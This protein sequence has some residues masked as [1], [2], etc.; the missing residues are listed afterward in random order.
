M[1]EIVE[2]AKIELNEGEI[3]TISGAPENM[4]DLDFVH[5][6]S[7]SHS[8]DELLIA[9]KYDSDI[10]MSDE[11]IALRDFCAENGL[12]FKIE[13]NRQGDLYHDKYEAAN[14]IEVFCD[15]TDNEYE[16]SKIYIHLQ[17]TDTVAIFDFNVTDIG[18][19]DIPFSESERIN[20]LMKACAEDGEA[21]ILIGN[22]ERGEIKIK[23]RFNSLKEEYGVHIEFVDEIKCKCYPGGIQYKHTEKDSRTIDCKDMQELKTV[24]GNAFMC[25]QID[26]KSV[27]AVSEEELKSPDLNKGNDTDETK[28]RNGEINPVEI[29]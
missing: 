22:D 21:T 9:D 24:L 8:K 16:C 3:I 20:W 19:E 13:G 25:A 2:K 7:F 15:I 18:I 5:K 6:I 10:L 28:D 27:M 12:I 17:N 1:A 26:K 11:M 29:D 4:I 14:G 23:P